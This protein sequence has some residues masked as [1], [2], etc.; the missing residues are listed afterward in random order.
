MEIEPRVELLNTRLVTLSDLTDVLRDQQNQLHGEKLEWIVI[1]LITV[2]VIV[3][4]VGFVLQY[5]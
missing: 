5:E 3:G 2:E 1:V 4:I